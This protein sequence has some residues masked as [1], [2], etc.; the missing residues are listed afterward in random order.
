MANELRW[1][2][3]RYRAWFLF[4]LTAAY[5]LNFLDRQLLAILA[6]PIRA[7]LHLSDTSLGLLGGVYFAAFYTALSLPMAW[8]ADRFDRTR[9][10][11]GAILVWSV[12]TATCGLA[13][14]F[15]HLA[16]SRIAV[17]IGESA[18]TPASYS[19]VADLYPRSR[20]A[21]ATGLFTTGSALGSALGLALG[22]LIAQQW[23]WRWAFFLLGLPGILLAIVVRMTLVEPPRGFADERQ[24][25]VSPAPIGTVFRVLFRSR[26]FPCLALGVG[27]ASICGYALSF[28]SASLLVRSFD[29]TIGEAGWRFALASGVGGILGGLVG[30]HVCDR[31]AQ[32][33]RR[34]LLW[35]PALALAANVP[36]MAGLYFASSAGTA[37]ALLAVILFNYHFWGGA[38]HAIVQGIVGSR[39]RSVAASAFLL[40]INVVGLTFGPT[41]V[42]IISDAL[43]GA[44]GSE[45]LR[46]SLTLIS[47]FFLVAAL[48]LTF[49]ATTLRRELDN[50]PA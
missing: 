39:M 36:L 47:P 13:Q 43:G 28:W 37:L 30:G 33:D 27:T 19:L 44:N 46:L 15:S 24:E 22:G 3:P 21:G 25:H 12:A 42:G 31:L 18:A 14:K 32:K 23:G 29:M 10:I 20:R 49:G 35:A 2:R 40:T 41:L 16:V 9:L 6:E 38:G 8:V 1:A 48:L 11:A 45:S 26:T 50:A 4:M 34:W 5:T 17:A 7:E